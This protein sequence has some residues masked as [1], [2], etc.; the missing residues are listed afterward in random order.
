MH[1]RDFEWVGFWRFADALALFFDGIQGCR[2]EEP[3]IDEDEF[4][5]GPPLDDDDD[6]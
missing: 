4:Y 3:P 2:Y 6:Y 5:Y 1:L